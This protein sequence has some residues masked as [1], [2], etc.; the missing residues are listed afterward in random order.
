M[1]R[2]F[3]VSKM[4]RAAFRAA[5]SRPAA[6]QGLLPRVPTLL[7]GRA[8]TYVPI[9][10]PLACRAFA[11]HS[12]N[13]QHQQHQHAGGGSRNPFAFSIS[14]TTLAVTAAA[15]VSGSLQSMTSQC[16]GAVQGENVPAPGEKSSGEVKPAAVTT[17]KTKKP[18]SRR[19]LARR[20]S[21]RKQKRHYQYVIVGA[22]TTTYA[23]IEAIRAVD[24]DA[25]ILIISD[26]SKLPRID[27]D[28]SDEDQL[29]ECDS[30]ADTYNEWRRHVNSRLENE[31]D[32][33]STSPVSSDARCCATCLQR[34]LS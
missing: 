18:M 30:L 21:M 14:A 19:K 23:A 13:G 3:A 5:P 28:S 34:Q 22:G 27:I 20:N 29:L 4:P 10:G 31:P 25:D 1:I 9:D 6:T 2:A 8:N 24:V 16:D 33:Y 17:T 7:L 26:Q 32:A 11:A 15:L 12:Y